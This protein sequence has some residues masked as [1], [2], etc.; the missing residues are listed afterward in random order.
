MNRKDKLI[1]YKKEFENIHQLIDK[2]LELSYFDFLRIRNFKL[3]NSTTENEVNISKITNR[4]FK[5]AEE[6]KIQESISELLKLEGVAVPI[7][8]TILA[9]KFPERFAII[10]RRVI[11]QLGKKE[12]LKDYLKNPKTYEEYILLMRKTKPSNISLRDYERNL[13][14]KD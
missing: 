1:W 2:K 3:Q 12:W 5:L 13:F 8:S 4:A 11:N 10:D 7:A 6:D 9:M 14:E